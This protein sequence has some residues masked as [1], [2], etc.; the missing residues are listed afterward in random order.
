MNIYYV[1]I[2][3]YYY[4]VINRFNSVIISIKRRKRVIFVIQVKNGNNYK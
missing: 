2:N 3:V 4:N 1:K